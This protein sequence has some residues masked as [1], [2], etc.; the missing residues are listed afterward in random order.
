M[1]VLRGHDAAAEEALKT[2]PLLQM[3]ANRQ[4]DVH[5]AEPPAWVHQ[6]SVAHLCVLRGRIRRLYRTEAAM[7]GWRVP[8]CVGARVQMF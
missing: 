2:M 4:E 3:C 5:H 1:L 6:A 8:V 7:I